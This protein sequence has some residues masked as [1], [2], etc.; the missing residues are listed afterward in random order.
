MSF[1]AIGGFVRTKTF[2]LNTGITSIFRG[3]GINN[4]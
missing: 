2:G 1:D 3:L 4:N